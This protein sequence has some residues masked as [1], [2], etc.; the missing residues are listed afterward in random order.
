MKR[1]TILALGTSTLMS[2]GLLGG[3][4]T[5]ALADTSPAE[6]QVFLAAPG[7]LT[8]A[9][10]AAEASSGGKAMSAEFEEDGTDAGMYEV[11]I[12]MPD[13]SVAEYLVNPADN[14][15]RLMPADTDDGD[16]DDENESN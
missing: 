11:E 5:M 14:S 8:A 15:V 9:V 16:D 10:S 2:L 13:G 12:V 4:A 7:S 1:T 3:A 6:A